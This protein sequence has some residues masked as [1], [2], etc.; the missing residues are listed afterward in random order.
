MSSTGS[1]RRTDNAPLSA[2]FE[3]SGV[4]TAVATVLFTAVMVSF[5]PFQPGGAD[6]GNGGGDIVNQLGFGSLGALSIFSLFAFT[7]MRKVRFLFSPSWMVLLGFFLLSVINA[8][9]P[10]SAFRAASFTLIG[11]LTLATVLALPRDADALSTVLAVSGFTVVIMCYAGVLLN[12][13]IA[14]HSADSI[15]PQH[16]GLWRGA[17]SHKNIAGPVMACFSFAGIYL[18]RRGW[19]W[20]G[21]LLFASAMI[22]MLHTGSKTTAGLVPLSIL[23]VV[24]P[25]LIG[26]RLGTPLLFALAVTGTALATLGIVFIEPIKSLAAHYLPDLTYTGRTT[27]W[28][29]AGEMLARHPWLGYGYESFWQTPL[30]TNQDKAF[31]SAW[32]IRSIVHGHNGYLDI[33][34]LMGIPALCA[35]VYTF[36][37][38]PLRDY[39]RIPLYKENVYLGDFFMMVV[40]FTALNAF[41]ESFFFRRADPV[42]MFF[43]FGILGLRLVSRFVMEGRPLR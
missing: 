34:V 16:A 42:W 14:I 9:D 40:L 35:A 6:L 41:L 12:P 15:E 37:I 38:A 28:E 33:A 3:R 7:D 27:L 1:L 18:F 2:A 23:V 30:L 22:F 10:P 20:S 32:D 13:G 24:M 8:A 26:M 11:I 29:F 4:A 19:R 39:M 31:D 5:R 17:F 21:F 25:G 43:V 36:L